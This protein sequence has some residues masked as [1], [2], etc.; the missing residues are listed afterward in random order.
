MEFF[1][2]HPKKKVL[3]PL[4]ETKVNAGFPSP[5][6]D[7]LE[8]KLDLNE[9]LV[10]H[11]SSTFIIKVNGDS[12]TG[13]GIFDRSLLVVDRSLTYKKNS[14]VIACVDNEFTVKK[15]DRI[16]GKYYLIS[17]NKDFEPILVDEDNE[18]LVWGIVTW[19]LNP[20]Y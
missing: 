7:Y 4:V 19:V 9:H 11:P 2:Y 1:K 17:A 15:I 18:L 8:Q 20:K 12:M 3:I 10:K 16:K 5:A 14:I 6:Q 13:E